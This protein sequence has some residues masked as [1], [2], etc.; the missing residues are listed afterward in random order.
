MGL[1]YEQ[2][3][4]FFG[5]SEQNARDTQMT[6]RVTERLRPSFLASRGF[7][8]QHSRGRALPLLNLKKKRDCSQSMMGFKLVTPA[9]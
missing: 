3:L 9:R 6:T 4:F 5:P 2:S 1:D 7:A 8:A